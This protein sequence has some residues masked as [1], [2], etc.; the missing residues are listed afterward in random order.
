MNNF[1]I[2]FREFKDAK[3][4]EGT[5]PKLCYCKNGFFVSWYYSDERILRNGWEVV[6]G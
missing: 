5:K 1:L 3:F 4:I 6:Y 2:V